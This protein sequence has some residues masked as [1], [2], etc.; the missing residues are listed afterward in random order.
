[1]AIRESEI[2][3]ESTKAWVHA[4]AKKRA[5]VVYRIGATASSTDSAY[6]MSQDG[7]SIA[8]ARAKYLSR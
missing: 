8:I 6:D 3:F 2:L 1:M 4:D 5:Y 7:L